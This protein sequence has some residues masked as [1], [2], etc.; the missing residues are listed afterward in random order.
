MRRFSVHKVFPL[1]FFP[2]LACLLTAACQSS[3]A[4]PAPKTP[5]AAAPA[6]KDSLPPAWL[7]RHAVPHPVRIKDYFR[8]IDG[9][10]RQYDT[11]TPYPLNEHLLVRANPWIIDS[12][13]NTDYYRLRYNGIFVYDQ[14]RLVILHPGDTLLIPGTTLARELLARQAKTWIDINIPE[15]RLRIVE[16][17]DTLYT[18]PVRVGQHKKRYQTAIGRVADL[19]TQPGTGKIIRINRTPSLFEDPHTGRRFSTT[20]RD[21][22]RVTAMPLIPWL[23]PEINGKRL[24]QMIHPT[25]NLE[26]LEKAYSN[27]CIGTSEADAWR[28]Y[29]YAPLGTPVHIRYDLKVRGPAG[30]T[31][32]LPDI[33]DW[34]G[35][36][37]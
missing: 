3:P 37:K 10:V 8:F 6:K 21:D 30:N 9:V 24:G 4:V 35:K 28:L 25:T 18:M 19:R 16:G 11:L 32:E 17:D 15:Y 22:R 36:T 1:L 14:R 2:L 5:V 26:T 29:Y 27:G 31:I 20:K 12:L 34:A 23:E 13:E 33:Y 7:Y